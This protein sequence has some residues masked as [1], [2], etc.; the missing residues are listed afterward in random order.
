MKILI[1]LLLAAWLT[2]LQ[3]MA[4]A[5]PSSTSALFEAVRAGDHAAVRSLIKTGAGVNARDDE[6]NTPLIAAALNADVAVLKLLIEAGAEVNA[7]NQAGASALLR[8]AAFEDKARLLVTAGADFKARSQLGNGVLIL[9]ARKPGNSGTVKLLLDRGVEVN[10]TNG[11]G[12]T[13][14]MAAVAAEDTQSVRL[15]LDQGADVNAGPKMND[16]GFLFGGGRSPLMWAAFRGNEELTRL[17]LARGANVNG[18]SLM[19]GALKQAAWAGNTTIARV[20]LDA[21]AQVDQRDRRANYTPLHWAAS[22]EKFDATLVQLLLARGADVNAEGGQTLDNFLGVA[23]TPLM[24]ALK[25]GETPIVAA[26]RKAGAHEVEPLSKKPNA[27]P[28]RTAVSSADTDTMIDAIRRALPPLQKSAVESK[29]TY[30]RHAS[31]QDC[32]SCH[33]QSLPLSAI[34]VALSRHFAVDE[35]A[36]NQMVADIGRFAVMN[37]E[38][39]LE[40]TFHPAPAIQYGY[41]LLARHLNEQTPS[42]STDS[43][44]HFLTVMQQADGHWAWNLP[45]PPIQSS[46]IVAT[47][48]AMQ[49]IQSYAPPGRKHEINERVGRAQAWLLKAK[50]EG[51]EERAYQ[52]LGLAWAGERPDRLKPFAE[53]LIRDQRDDG[54][55]SQLA[56]LSSD[57]YAT[58]QALYSLQVAG[59]GAG[60]PAV[61][62]GIEFLLRTQLDDGTWYVAT[63]SH[64]FQPS[65]ESGFPHG[66][67]GWISCAATCWAVMALATSLD[68]SEVPATIPAIAWFQSPAPSAASNAAIEVAGAVEF[69]RDIQPLLE[70][71]CVAC[72]S[73]EKPKGGFQVTGRTALL[74]G[75]KRGDAVVI[76]GKADASP[77][78]RF[79]RDQV[80]DME[81]PPLDKRGKYPA[82]TTDETL[83]LR[84][85]I[86]RGAVWPEGLSLRAAGK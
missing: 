19:G 83:R 17:L 77:L 75:G 30:L 84:A 39:N 59:L 7:T 46:D 55:W 54:G 76:P 37:Q 70:R 24:L 86:N 52:L 29:A 35:T 82:L 13:A 28:A 3:S 4:A 79:V 22:S 74:K 36:L 81:M 5:P 68:P 61:R 20:L 44:V 26:L 38:R 72:H 32:V 56:K 60:H 43:Q 80:E 16:Q 66:K 18:V 71:S 12:G 50:P 8:A 27:A 34:G 40:A 42:M 9:A 48:L 47:A 11:F 23:Q 33:Q 67:D 65:M 53:A 63:R 25:R 78:V 2:C 6:G 1:A 21:G 14:L 31:R 41:T 51:N 62:K 57:A 64:P 10:A 45:R 15:L 58:G 49:A 85:W 69:T 73:G